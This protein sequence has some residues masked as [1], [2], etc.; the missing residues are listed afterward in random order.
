MVKRI[1]HIDETGAYQMLPHDDLMIESI[2]IT[3]RMILH[4]NMTGRRRIVILTL[5]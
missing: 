4:R 5:T 3:E 1:V 2:E